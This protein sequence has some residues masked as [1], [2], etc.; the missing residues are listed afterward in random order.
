MIVGGAGAYAAAKKH[1]EG[2][3]MAEGGFVHWQACGAWWGLTQQP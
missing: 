1:M 3:P 2:Q